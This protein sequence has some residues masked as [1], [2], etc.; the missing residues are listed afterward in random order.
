[1][2]AFVKSVGT[3]AP[4]RRG[5][6]RHNQLVKLA[7]TTGTGEKCPSAT[8]SP[9]GKQ[10]ESTRG[11]G[12]PLALPAFEHG[13]WMA[14]LTALVPSYPVMVMTLSTL[15]VVTLGQWGPGLTAA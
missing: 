9:E 3:N 4:G 14:K 7:E 1:M 5:P 6:K 12:S 11:N 8:T 15:T 10:L 13:S 2:T